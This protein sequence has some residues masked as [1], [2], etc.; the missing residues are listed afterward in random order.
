MWQA[1]RCWVLAT[2][3]LP[4]LASA[5]VYRWVDDEGNVH[6]SD[7]KPA[8]GQAQEIEIETRQ[9]P[10]EPD[11]GE[12]RRLDLVREAEAR[13]RETVRL[14]PPQEAPPFDHAAACR[15]ARRSYGALHETMP[16]YRAEDGNYRAQWHGDAYE[17]ARAYVADED[18][19]SVI[20]EVIARLHE[21]CQNPG[22]E[23]AL[24]DEYDAYIA[25][26]YCEAARL[27]LAA[28]S[29]ESSRTSE[30]DLQKLR[31]EVFRTCD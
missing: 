9:P 12:Q 17:G 14:S 3:L 28:A 24:Y 23:Q 19:A 31:R 25:A 16:V 22:D 29:R 7:K 30:G 20:D 27:R 13:F 11:E 21:H 6:F 18:R 1:I 4:G 8:D 26:E 2:L 5:E 15:D 10:A